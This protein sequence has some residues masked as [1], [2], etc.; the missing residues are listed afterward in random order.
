MSDVLTG[1]GRVAT[2]AAIELFRLL[3][4]LSNTFILTIQN[5]TCASPFR[6]ALYKLPE[7]FLLR[8]KMQ[9]PRRSSRSSVRE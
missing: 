7:A 5:A 6:A 9:F 2:G 1:V 8:A 3:E 4:T